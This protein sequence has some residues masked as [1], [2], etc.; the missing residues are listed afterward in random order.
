MKNI[1]YLDDYINLYNS[2]KNKIIKIKPYKNTLFYGH[3][4]DR[5]KF[6]KLYNK[7]LDENKINRNFFNEKIILII[8]SSYKKEDRNTLKLFLEELNYKEID[9]INE[10]DIIKMNKKS[11]IVNYNYEYFNLCYIDNLNKTKLVSYE[12]NEINRELIVSI[13]KKLKKEDIFLI[14]KN[15]LEL[16]NIL[17][18]NRVNYY[19]FEES[20]NIFI[21]KCLIC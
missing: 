11:L 13:I 1:L 17:D 4:I 6:I 19:Y 3:I 14:G 10:V 12:N 2:K 20:E 18:K 16:R 5:E 15:I 8:N 7:C 9:F 21:K